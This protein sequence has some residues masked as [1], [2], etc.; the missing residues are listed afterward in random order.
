MTKYS[1]PYE[2]CETYDHGTVESY[3]HGTVETWDYGGAGAGGVTLRIRTVRWEYR[4][5]GRGAV[6]DDC[7]E[8]EVSCIKWQVIVENAGCVMS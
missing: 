3:D 4:L 8:A 2:T 1:A 6:V 5:D 7:V